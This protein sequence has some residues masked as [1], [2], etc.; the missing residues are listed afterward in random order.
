MSD[1]EMVAYTLF[2]AFDTNQDGRVSI[3]ELQSALAVDTDGDGQTTDIQQSRTLP[4]GSTATWTELAV[5]QKAVNAYI[6]NEAVYGNG[7]GEITF[8]EFLRMAESGST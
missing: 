4:D 6:V 5:L 2:N 3:G 8:E 7:D 1:I